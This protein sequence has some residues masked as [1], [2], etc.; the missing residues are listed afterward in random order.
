MPSAAM[1]PSAIRKPQRVM[2]RRS[3]RP[4]TVATRSYLFNRSVRSTPYRIKRASAQTLHFENGWN[5]LDASGGAAVTGIGHLSTRVEQ[6][7]IKTLKRGIAYISSM[8]FDTDVA[9]DFARF[10]IT[11][12]DGKMTRAVFYS[13][14]TEANEAAYK[15]ALQYHATE[16]ANPEPTRTLF[17]ARDR[18]YHGT[19]LGALDMSGHK[20]RRELYERVLP[21]NTHHISPC[22]AYRGLQTGESVAEYVTRL[23]NELEQ[24]IQDLGPK[25]VAAFICEPVVGAAL[26]CVPA[27]AG[28]LAAMREV[29]DR[30]GILLIFDEVMCGMGRTGYLHAWQKEGVAPDIQTV[31]KGLAGGFQQLSA[32]LVSP[33]VNDAFEYGPGS[34]AFSHGHTFQNYPLACAAGLEVQKIIQEENLLQNVKEKGFRLSKS[35]KKR[36]S[37]HRHVGD[38]RGAGLFWG[39]E[40]VKDKQTMEPFPADMKINW[41]IYEKGLAPPYEI[42]V[43]PGMGTAD[44]VNGDHIIL[45][46]S[47]NITDTEIDAIV[48]RVARLIED[49]FDTLDV[50]ATP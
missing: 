30:Y 5:V 6:V 16:K 12:T 15:V 9:E 38:I 20:A 48:D 36:L 11:T 35:L 21:H 39:I 43:Y 8:M 27:E 25:N 26:G 33:K 22:Y 46:P 7:M 18:S 42:H 28:Y 14:G 10:L 37:N 29:C 47:Y 4:A 50:P 24:K 34:G 49:Y 1:A 13:S 19:T 2:A 23:K 31:G 17:I 3:S 44:G 40:F 41:R 32:M 45:S